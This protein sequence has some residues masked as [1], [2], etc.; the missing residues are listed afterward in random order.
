MR[1]AIH[2]KPGSA[3]TR[4]GGRHGDALV[5]SVT[6][7]AVDGK[8]TAAALQAVADAFDVRPRDICLVTGAT[9]R[10]K[11]LDIAGEAAALASRRDWLLGPASP[12]A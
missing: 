10:D 12:P 2:V 3:R 11:V 4:V 9:S 1:I 5:V 8:A 7:R 6:A